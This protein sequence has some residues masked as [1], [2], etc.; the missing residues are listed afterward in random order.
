MV[1][2]SGLSKAM[3]RG[4]SLGGLGLRKLCLPSSLVPTF[5][6]IA[7]PNTALGERGIETCGVLAGKASPAG[8]GSLVVTHLVLPPQVGKPDDCE[9]TGDEALLGFCM[10]RGLLTL[11]WIH[12][13]PSQACFMSSMDLHTHAGYQATLPE[14]VAIV[15]APRERMS[16]VYRLTDDGGLELV[17]KCEVSERR[18]QYLCWCGLRTLQR[19]LQETI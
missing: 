4:A 19:S 2:Y 5:E 17:Q 13:H 3:M 7:Q 8:D 1:S 14:A 6:A 10:E 12:T 11:G 15:V 16:A 18:W 9:V